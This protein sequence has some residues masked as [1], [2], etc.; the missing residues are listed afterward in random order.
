VI[1][2]LDTGT[3]ILRDAKSNLSRLVPIARCPTGQR[4]G[5]RRFARAREFVLET[6]NEVWVSAASVRQIAIKRAI[7]RADMP[8]SG[9][10]ALA[11]FRRAG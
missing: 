1:Y 7:G 2:L 5:A 4:I 10:E 11:G 6:T 9:D 3:P 8:V